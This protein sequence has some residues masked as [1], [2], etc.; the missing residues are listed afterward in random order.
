MPDHHREGCDLGCIGVSVCPRQKHNHSALA[1]IQQ[2]RQRG[3]F[4]G[5]RAQDIRRTYIARPDVAQVSKAHDAGKD[6]AKRD[7]PNDVG[8]HCP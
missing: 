1:A 8:N 3:G 2:Q 7:R 6:E 5:P 4:F